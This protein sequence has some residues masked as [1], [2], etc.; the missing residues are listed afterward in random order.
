LYGRFKEQP[1]PTNLAAYKPTIDLALKCFGEDRLICR[2]DWPVVVGDVWIL[3]GSTTV[4]SEL[5]G[6]LWTPASQVASP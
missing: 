3:T 4:S 6:D 1:A 2:S 5:V